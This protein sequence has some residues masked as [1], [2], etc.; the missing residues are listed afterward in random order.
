MACS[1]GHLDNMFLLFCRWIVIH[2]PMMSL[3]LWIWCKG[4]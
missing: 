4:V 2:Q 1:Q 3:D